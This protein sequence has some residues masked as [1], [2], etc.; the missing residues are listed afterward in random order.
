STV[1]RDRRRSSR[2][3][4]PLQGPLRWG[5]HSRGCDSVISLFSSHPA[6]VPP[7]AAH[8]S[9]YSICPD[10]CVYR[11]LCDTLDA[12]VRLATG[13]TSTPFSGRFSAKK[14]REMERLHW[15]KG[16]KPVLQGLS[17]AF[18]DN[19]RS[20]SHQAQRLSDYTK[21]TG[22]HFAVGADGAIN[23]E[24]MPP[25]SQEPYYTTSSQSQASQATP[26]VQVTP[27]VQK[28]PTVEGTPEPPTYTHVV[29][30]VGHKKEEG[31]DCFEVQENQ[32][33]N[34][35][36]GGFRFVAESAFIAAY[37]PEVEEIQSNEVVDI[38]K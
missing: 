13:K 35:W 37:V 9:S 3:A 34:A 28:T 15:M 36:N 20:T 16:P 14:L 4:G 11:S 38:S 26:T 22:V 8:L 19:W 31:I 5:S 29:C 27:T 21:K 1:A 24:E 6:A 23:R 2:V 32:G 25:A 12:R 7:S 18:C 10:T 17:D 30:V 33:V